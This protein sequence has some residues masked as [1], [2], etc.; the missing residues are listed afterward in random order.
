MSGDKFTVL[1][2]TSHRI[3]PFTGAA[4]AR[5]VFTKIE[6]TTLAFDLGLFISTTQT[7]LRETIDQNEMDSYMAPFIRYLYYGDVY[8]F[9]VKNYDFVSRLMYENIVKDKVGLN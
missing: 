6:K 7:Q 2:W 4:L 1:F 9:G 8:S 3:C 5:M